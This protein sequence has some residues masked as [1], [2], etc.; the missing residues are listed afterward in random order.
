MCLDL[1]AILFH[2]MHTC[3]ENDRKTQQKTDSI[4]PMV[5]A[6]K[7]L[8]LSNKNVLQN[9]YDDCKSWQ[10]PES[11]VS[12]SASQAS[13][14]PIFIWTFCFSHH[15]MLLIFGCKLFDQAKQRAICVLKHLSETNQQQSE[16]PTCRR[17]QQGNTLDCWFFE[18]LK[19]EFCVSMFCMD[20]V[21][22]N[23][24]PKTDFCCSLF[25]WLQSLPAVQKMTSLISSCRR[26]ELH[27]KSIIICWKQLRLTHM[28]GFLL[29]LIMKSI[30]V[31][32]QV[33]LVEVISAQ[34]WVIRTR[35]HVQNI[36][37]TV[38][39]LVCEGSLQIIAL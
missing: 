22:W 38:C 30:P 17:Q 13:P 11:P 10:R 36:S 23:N 32:L 12:C 9:C 16:C 34:R 7:S 29:S 33:V 6:W 18:W 3:N 39:R 20:I 14:L 15:F 8:T 4:R 2:H 35:Q 31:F 1:F 24:S 21:I 28:E 26:S 5:D 37:S 19:F 27:E 25:L